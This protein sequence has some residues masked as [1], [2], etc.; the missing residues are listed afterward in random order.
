ML[1]VHVKY[2]ST[3]KRV[4]QSKAQRSRLCTLARS[5]R[6]EGGEEEEEEE[7]EAEE[8][9]EDEDAVD[10]AGLRRCLCRINTA[11]SFVVTFAIYRNNEFGRSAQQYIETIVVPC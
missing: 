11:P 2:A 7:A 1:F 9:E 4:C 5:L 3:N 6:R 10:C 8:D